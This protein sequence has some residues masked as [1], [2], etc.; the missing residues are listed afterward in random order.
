VNRL[1]AESRMTPTAF[2]RDV[3]EKGTIGAP[4]AI[5]MPA[6][7]AQRVQRRLAHSVMFM[8]M[9]AKYWLNRD[10][11]ASCMM[12]EEANRRMSDLFDSKKDDFA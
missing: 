5:E 9:V 7:L 3:L 8:E 4:S 6:H 2:A 1:S 11:E 12:H 10:E